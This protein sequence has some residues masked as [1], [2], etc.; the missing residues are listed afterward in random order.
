[1]SQDNQVPTF[2]ITGA[3]GGL[4][5]ALALACGARGARVILLDRKRRPLERLCDQVEERGGPPPGYGELDLAQ[6]GP[7]ALQT[8]VQELLEAYGGIDGLVHCAAR[9]DG[10]RPLD[11]ISPQDWLL[12][13][14][15]NLNAPWLLTMACLPALRKRQGSVVFVTDAI[16]RGSAYWGGYGVAKGGLE[17]LAA[18]LSE[19]LEESGCTVMTVD[20]GPMRTSLR[21]AAFM[22]EDPGSVPVAD[23]AAAQIADMLLGGRPD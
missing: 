10:L 5:S 11:Q 15:V 1:M 18:T 12:D 4:G 19:E 22:A 17:T 23:E 14:Q 13:L 7:E 21:S 20:P 2:L 8:F 16:A 6:V 9:F 3:T